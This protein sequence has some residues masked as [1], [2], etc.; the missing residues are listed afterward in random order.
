DLKSEV[1]EALVPRHFRR[2]TEKLGVFPVSQ[3][4]VSDL[5]I[6]EGEPLRFKA[7]FEVMP[8]IRV[9]GYRELRAEKPAITVTDD[10]VEQSLQALRE[11]HASFTQDEGRLLQDGDYAQASLDGKPKADE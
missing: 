9:E 5:H 6:H 10:E 7:S 2:E 4:R 3:P 8:E 1:V 11:Q